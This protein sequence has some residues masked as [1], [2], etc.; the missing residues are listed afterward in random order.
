M[1]AALHEL[2]SPAM[3]MTQH[4]LVHCPL[5]FLTCHDGSSALPILTSHD[6]DSA[7]PAL[8]SAGFLRDWA[9]P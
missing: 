5:P 4:F 7:L 2:S 8:S 3:M 9:C 1:M 6:D